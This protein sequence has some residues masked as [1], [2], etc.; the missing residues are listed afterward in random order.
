MNKP[1]IFTVSNFFRQM[2]LAFKD[3]TPREK[4]LNHLNSLRQG[5]RSFSEPLSELDPQAGGHQWEDSLRQDQ[6][7]R[8]EYVKVAINYNTLHEWL[9]TVSEDPTLQVKEIADSMT[10]LQL[11]HSGAPLMLSAS[12]PIMTLAITPMSQ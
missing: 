1:A 9:V 3:P 5:N 8:S 11:Q 6:V 10:G 12:F 4:A 2:Q 7:A